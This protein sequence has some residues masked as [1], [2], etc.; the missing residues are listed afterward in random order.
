M[1]ILL[2]HDSKLQLQSVSK[3]TEKKSP[4]AYTPQEG[5]LRYKVAKMFEDNC[6]VRRLRPKESYC[7]T[8]R[9]LFFFACG[10][11]GTYKQRYG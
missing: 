7:R 5:I 2:G 9:S 10:T 3:S 8:W 6:T 11:H 1:F 4:P